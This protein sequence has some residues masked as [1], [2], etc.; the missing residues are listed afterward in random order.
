M[1]RET[2]NQFVLWAQLFANDYVNKKP[3][4]VSA[5]SDLSCMH[6]QKIS[7]FT[8]ANV[9]LSDRRKTSRH[10]QYLPS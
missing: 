5:V 2:D 10:E 9:V 3:K 6:V 8:D 1:L 4:Q 7:A